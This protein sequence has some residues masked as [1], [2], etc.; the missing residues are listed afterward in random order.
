M[1]YF[2]LGGMENLNVKWVPNFWC[3]LPIF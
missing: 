3:Q 1:I 2:V